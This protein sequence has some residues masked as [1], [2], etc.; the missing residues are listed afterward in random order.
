MFEFHKCLIQ[1]NE[2]TRRHV[3]LGQPGQE[4]LKTNHPSMA[5]DSESTTQ[6]QRE[7]VDTGGAGKLVH[8]AMMIKYH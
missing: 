3:R 5:V 6:L 4:I 2:I 7:R 1:N 8:I